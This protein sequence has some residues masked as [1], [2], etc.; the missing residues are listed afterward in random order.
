METFR[1]KTV[2]NLENEIANYGLKGKVT[3]STWQEI[4]QRSFKQ[5]DPDDLQIRMPIIDDSG[6]VALKI[7]S[8]CYSR[9]LFL[10]IFTSPWAVSACFIMLYVKGHRRK[11]NFLLWK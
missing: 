5:T 2:Y 4:D 1:W 8:F 6:S 9:K 7:T 10:V 3:N 11:F